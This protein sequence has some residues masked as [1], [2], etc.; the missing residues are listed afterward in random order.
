MIQIGPSAVDLACRGGWLA[1][2]GKK[3]GPLAVRCEGD[4]WG[5]ASRQRLYLE[6]AQD[7]IPARLAPTVR[8]MA[9]QGSRWGS[10][11]SLTWADETLGVGNVG[12]GAKSENPTNAARNIAG[13]NHSLKLA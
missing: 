12:G 4:G 5:V 9:V 13:F 6:P 1:S 10:S 7:A 11:S 3:T 8:H 2:L